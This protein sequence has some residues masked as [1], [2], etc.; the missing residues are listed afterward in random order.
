MRPLQYDQALIWSLSRLNEKY[1]EF[2]GA[3]WRMR[4]LDKRLSHSPS[5]LELQKADS[6][7]IILTKLFETPKGL[8]EEFTLSGEFWS[9][10]GLY[11]G[12]LI[13]D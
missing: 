6:Q 12:K 3:L 10:R 7:T 1:T 2:D 5:C 9:L 13:S 4:G 8:D 11:E